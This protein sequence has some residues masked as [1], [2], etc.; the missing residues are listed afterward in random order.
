M[1]TPAQPFLGTRL[2]AFDI[3]MA[4]LW[5]TDMN[6]TLT[7]RTLAVREPVLE[8]LVRG[9]Q[10]VHVRIPF[11]PNLNPNQL[12]TLVDAIL[13][14]GYIYRDCVTSEYGLHHQTWI[15]CLQ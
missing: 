6:H 4:R 1:S 11:N 9:R 12:E 10:Q 14:L 8:E 15:F 3:H 13:R 2:V 7:T 5:T